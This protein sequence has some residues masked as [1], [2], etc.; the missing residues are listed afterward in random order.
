MKITVKRGCI[1]NKSYNTAHK[2]NKKAHIS[3]KNKLTKKE[4]NK[5]SKKCAGIL[6]RALDNMINSI[7]DVR[8]NKEK[9]ILARRLKEL[10]EM[11]PVNTCS[12]DDDMDEDSNYDVYDVEK[13]IGFKKMGKKTLY[14]VKWVGY[15]EPT[16][17]PADNGKNDG[18]PSHLVEE[19]YET[20]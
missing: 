1:S 18:I 10:E 15:D 9:I 19:Y 14:L 3:K 7:K 2:Y 6:R 17:E 8:A 11:N 13:I 20:I 12:I 4:I 16:W 5:K